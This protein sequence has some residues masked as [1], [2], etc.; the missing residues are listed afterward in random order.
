MRADIPQHSHF[1]FRET[2]AALHITVVL[3]LP[4]GT[5]NHNDRL[6]IRGS[7]SFQHLTAQLHFFLMPRFRRPASAAVIKGV[8][9]YPVLIDLRQFFINRKNL[10]RPQSI[11]NADRILHIYRSARSRAAAVGSNLHSSK[12]CDPVFSG[13]RQHMIIIFQKND[14]LR[15]CFSGKSCETLLGNRCLIYIVHHLSPPSK[16]SYCKIPFKHILQQPHL[17]ISNRLL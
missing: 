17:F 15:R 12:H 6:I 3:I 7:G 9:R 8:L 16:R 10:L 1:L 2:I 13:K 14:S 4:G 5:A 11:Q